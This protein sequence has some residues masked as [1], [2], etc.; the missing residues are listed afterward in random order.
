MDVVQFAIRKKACTTN[1]AKYITGFAM[2]AAFIIDGAFSF[3]DAFA[4]F[5]DEDI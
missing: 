5:N 4:F 1:A 2:Y 3:E